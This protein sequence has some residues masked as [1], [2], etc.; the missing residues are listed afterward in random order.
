MSIEQRIVDWN[1]ERGLI[2][3]PAECDVANNVAFIIEE[4]I[5]AL[6]KMES[7][8][9][10][11]S[12]SVIADVIRTGNIE[13]LANIAQEEK[14]NEGD[15]EI[16]DLDPEQ[17]VDAAGD[18]VV[19]S[20]GLI[21]KMGYNPELAMQEVLKEIESRKGSII[22]GKFTKDKSPEAQALWYKAN[23]KNAKI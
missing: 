9:A 17:V 11:K 4:C 15:S 8:E 2:K 3:T 7:V 18:T 14:L 22:G 19:F 10:R 23:F 1:S 21:R 12:A 6:T 13:K 20:I 5:E 16:E